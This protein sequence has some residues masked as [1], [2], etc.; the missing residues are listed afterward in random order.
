M[1]II[2]ATAD[3]TLDGLTLT[4]GWSPLQMAVRYF[5]ASVTLDNRPSAATAPP[6]SGGGIS[7]VTVNL[8]NSTVSGN[9]AGKHGGGIDAGTAI[10]PTRLSAET[11]R[12]DGGGIRASTANAHQFDCQRQQRDL[13]AAASHPNC[14]AHQH[15]CQRQPR[16]SYGGG[17]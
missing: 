14:D 2:S 16:G 9:S 12:A 15:D 4:G 1:R 13:A 11:A 10:S 17:I 3:L 5:D 6:I 8:T 7:A